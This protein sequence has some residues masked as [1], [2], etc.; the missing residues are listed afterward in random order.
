M[1]SCSNCE[2]CSDESEDQCTLRPGFGDAENCEQYTE[3]KRSCGIAKKDLEMLKLKVASILMAN[4]S[5][6]GCPAKARDCRKNTP[7]KCVD[8]WSD[9][10]ERYVFSEFDQEVLTDD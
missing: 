1:K 4:C 7:A 3:N 6:A 9:H 2:F 8:N 5:C 10:L